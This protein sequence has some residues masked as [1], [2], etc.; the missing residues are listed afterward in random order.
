MNLNIGGINF[1]PD[2]VGI[3][4]PLLILLLIPLFEL[5]LYPLLRKYKVNFSSL[6]KMTAGFVL[7][8]LSFIVAALLQI[9]IDKGLTAL[10]T[11]QQHGFRVVNSLN[12]DIQISMT[13]QKFNVPMNY[14]SDIRMLDIDSN[15]TKL[16]S[17]ENCD[18][19][20]N[21]ITLLPTKPGSV[22]DIF[23]ISST[24]FYKSEMK[25]KK[26]ENGDAR[27]TIMN[28]S[29]KDQ[30]YSVRGVS[31]STIESGIRSAAID[32]PHGM[33]TLDIYDGDTIINTYTSEVEV[34]GVYTFVLGE[35]NNDTYQIKDIN[36]NSISV[37]WILPQF[38][39]ITI[40]EVFLSITGLEF[41]YSQAPP[42][43]KSVLASVWLLTVSF[44]N[45][46]VLIVAEAKFVEKQANEFFL[47]A[48]LVLVAGIIFAW[49][50][51]R[52]KLVDENQFAGEIMEEENKKTKKL[53]TE[54]SILLDTVRQRLLN[55]PTE[56]SKV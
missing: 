12:C 11:P 28:A 36:P 9:Q 52:Y 2:Q 31:E 6:R 13:S 46:I 19:S 21:D 43:M 51:Y 29:P 14:A 25:T 42:S 1:K 45:V 40:G 5:T 55:D 54:E 34:G 26:S 38:V 23:L 18:G 16:I 47:F 10:P 24:V 50:A 33:L 20:T 17:F 39:I 44:G 37:L 4:N 22:E 3:I 15:I 48:G 35:G 30:K 7:T 32:V 53:K 8:G 27:L 49:L 56:N 41:S